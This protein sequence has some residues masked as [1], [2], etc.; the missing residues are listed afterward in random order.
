MGKFLGD[1]LFWTAVS[2]TI[3]WC[4]Y[5]VV[6]LFR[7]VWEIFFSE[8]PNQE[9]I[10]IKHRMKKNAKKFVGQDWNELSI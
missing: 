8:I 2:A 7:I 5:V 9:G 3:F 1:V 10:W 6:S 4:I